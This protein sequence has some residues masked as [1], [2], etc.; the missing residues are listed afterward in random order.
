MSTPRCSLSLVVRHVM[1]ITIIWFFKFHKA[2]RDFT[3]LYSCFVASREV[4]EVCFSFDFTWH[5]FESTEP[6]VPAFEREGLPQTQGHCS[7]QISLSPSY[8]SLLRL[9]SRCLLDF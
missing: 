7:W 6:Q 9:S 8:L 3:L 5:A 4:K 2:R 1:A